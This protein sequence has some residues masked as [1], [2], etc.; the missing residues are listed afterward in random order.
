MANIITNINSE[1]K[2]NKYLS[3]KTMYF[4]VGYAVVAYMLKNYVNHI[5]FIPYMLFSIGCAFFAVLP[6]PLNKR[7]SN[8]ESI[9]LLFKKDKLVYRPEAFLKDKETLYDERRVKGET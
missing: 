4:L 3:L 5:L 6:S 1:T 2:V 7:R 9:F 8:L